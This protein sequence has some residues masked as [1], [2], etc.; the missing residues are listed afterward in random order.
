MWDCLSLACLPPAVGCVAPFLLG[1]PDLDICNLEVVMLVRPPSMS[2]SKTW[3]R[4][5]F[6][7]WLS[8]DLPAKPELAGA[9]QWPCAAPCPACR[10]VTCCSFLAL[11]AFSAINSGT[12]ETT[13]LCP[14]LQDH[15]ARYRWLGR[16]CRW[17]AKTPTLELSVTARAC[18]RAGHPPPRSEKTGR[19]RRTTERVLVSLAKRI[20]QPSNH[21]LYRLRAARSLHSTAV[22]HR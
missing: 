6:F 7:C 15:P 21:T 16:G 1:S 18:R 4:G 9:L 3:N 20:G 13:R 11:L 2:S 19:Q 8:G 5:A 14:D 17:S 22:G 12:T 10:R